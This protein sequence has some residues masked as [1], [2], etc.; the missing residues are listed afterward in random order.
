M[1]L[2]AVFRII[3]ACL[4]L[5]PDVLTTVPFTST[6]FQYLSKMEAVA[7]GLTTVVSLEGVSVVS[8]VLLLWQEVK[9]PVIRTL[10]MI[11]MDFIVDMFS[12]ESYWFLKPSI[13]PG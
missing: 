7:G 9:I 8:G 3:W 6:S 1:R 13:H 11:S 5:S 12:D 2:S 4:E 10:V